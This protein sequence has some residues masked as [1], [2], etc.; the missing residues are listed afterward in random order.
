MKILEFGSYEEYRSV[1]VAANKLKYKN[2]YAEDSEIRRI[3]EHFKKAVPQARTGLCHGVRNGY[4]VRLFRRLLPDVNIVGT[5][6]ADTAA[7]LPNC[8]VWDMHEVKAEWV[9]N[10]DFMYSNSWDHTYDPEILFFRWS[11]CL[12]AGGRLYLAYTES[13]SESGA[14]EE[15]K[16]DAF[17]CSFDELLAIVGRVFIIDDIL[18]IA[19][20]LTKKVWRTRL[21]YLRAGRIGRLFRAPLS[22]RRVLVVVLKKRLQTPGGVLNS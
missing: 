20:R 17:G 3:A 22:S 7:Q 21:S 2:V 6:I 16:V 4:E 5:D 9:G 1:Q 14:T 18:E 12:S 19:P 13:H 15:T 8:I 10:T 11:E